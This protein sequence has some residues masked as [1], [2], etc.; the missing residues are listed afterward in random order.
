[1]SDYSDNNSDFGSNGDFS[2]DEM[3][4]SDIEAVYQSTSK[5]EPK[6]QDFLSIYSNIQSD[7]S[8]VSSI[9]NCHNDTSLY[10]LKKTGY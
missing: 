3:E 4:Y 7:A 9:F 2:D 6:K 8:W 1:M 5:T 10:L